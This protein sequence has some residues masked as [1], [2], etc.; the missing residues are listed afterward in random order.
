MSIFYQTVAKAV[1]LRANQLKDASDAASFDAA[2]K[3]TLASI[4]DGLELPLTALKAAVLT[5]EKELVELVAKTQNP[6]LRQ[7][8]K[9]VSASLSSGAELPAKSADNKAFIGIFGGVFD[10]ADNT[11]LT[12]QPLQT[13]LRRTRNSG[14]FYKTKQYIYHI[15]DTRIY[16]T[17]TG[18]KVEGCAYDADAQSI[19]FDSPTGKSPLPD[20]VENLLICETLAHI[21]QENWFQGESQIYLNLANAA[22]QQ[23]L[24]GAIPQI[25]MPEQTTHQEPVKN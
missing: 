18:V 20:A 7:T 14:N 17:C 2:Y 5:A 11:P 8:L 19:A 22:K 3:G 4:L 24:Q 12:E 25:T 16:H 10:A 15:A 21:A 6:I 9:S 1:A 23:I 13:V